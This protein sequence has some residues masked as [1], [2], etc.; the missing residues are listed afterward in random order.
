MIDQG[1]VKRL[2]N[3]F[4]VN[5][6]G[7][8]TR[9]I[10]ESVCLSCG[11]AEVVARGELDPHARQCRQCGFHFLRYACEECGEIVD[12]RDPD[13]S[14]CRDCGWPQCV[15]GVCAPA[16]CVHM[17]GKPGLLTS[18]NTRIVRKV[19]EVMQLDLFSDNRRTIRLNDAEELLGV[20]DLNGADTMYAELLEEFPGDGE[21]VRLRTEV[22]F[23]REYL[24]AGRPP[25]P[26][27]LREMFNLISPRTCQSLQSGLLAHIAAGLLE[28]PSPELVYTAP[29]FHLGCVLRKAGRHGEAIQWFGA[30]VAS[31]IS[32]RGRFL[33]W[34]GDALTE[35]MREEEALESYRNAFL[36]DPDT[37]DLTSLANS[38]IRDLLDE[39]EA[40]CADD[41]EDAGREEVVSWLPFWGWLRGV[42]SLD[43]NDIAD[44]TGAFVSKLRLIDDEDLL[45]LPRLWFEY[46][47]YAEF[48]RLGLRDDREQGRVR[49]RM[50]Q[51]DGPMF[52]RYM[53]RVGR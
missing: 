43:L 13:N 38:R 22:T 17:T 51:L 32:P 42:F 35:A 34:Q 52:A 37:V 36:D 23:W 33:A 14:C 47:R 29:D 27:S 53:K 45:P 48:L 28:L 7:I 49:L 50:K 40:E 10:M 3:Q 30:A 4:R 26:E 11:S 6:T 8:R 44:D 9:D 1:E 12:S 39:L 41:D 2:Y 16:G 18:G 15:C 24:S 5:R 46:L 31:G 21:L 20:L 25:A 19:P